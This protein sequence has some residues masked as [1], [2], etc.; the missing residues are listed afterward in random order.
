MLTILY[1]VYLAI[2]T[3]FSRTKFLWH[4]YVQ[5][6]LDGLFLIFW[7]AVC[8]VAQ[9]TCTQFMD[10]CANWM[11]THVGLITWSNLELSCG[12]YECFCKPYT[13]SSGTVK[14]WLTSATS[15]TES[16][17]IKITTKVADRQG[18]GAALV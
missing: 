14:R 15:K 4:P 13:T 9:P 11:S 6:G 3:C 5:L 10:A 17:G 12:L 16:T 8:A 2:S 7:I 1:I 18:V